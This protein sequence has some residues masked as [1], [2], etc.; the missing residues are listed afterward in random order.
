MNKREQATTQEPQQ[1]NEV[2]ETM[3]EIDVA[4]NENASVQQVD[5]TE[6]TLAEEPEA[7]P[8]AE[9]NE[10]VPGPAIVAVDAVDDG[11]PRYTKEEILRMHW[12]SHKHK[13]LRD[14]L[15]DD[16][17]YTLAEVDKLAN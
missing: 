14:K 17:R 5:E 11:F 8:E 1:V 15:D 6:V 10:Q 4:S 2:P 3:A 16:A 7:E 13:Y 9:Q 12:Y